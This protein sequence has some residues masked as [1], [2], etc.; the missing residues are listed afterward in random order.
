MKPVIG[1][2][3]GQRLTVKE[4]FL[5]NE[6]CEAIIKNGGLPLILPV[7]QQSELSGELLERCD[8]LMLTGGG[9]IKP[10]FYQ[11]VLIDSLAENIDESRDSFEIAIFKAALE[12]QK[13][14][15][16]ICRGLQ[17]IN[18]ALNG[19]LIQDIDRERPHS[20]VHRA[21]SNLETLEHRVSL[22][23]GTRA[24]RIFGP[25]IQVNSTHHQAVK[26]LGVGLVAVGWSP[27]G[28][29]EA[30]EGVEETWITAVQWHPERLLEQDG[31]NRLFR[32]LMNQ[33]RQ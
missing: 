14:V 29:I 12:G 22:Q 20:L 4:Q 13:P 2:S 6:Y 32:E 24:H 30:I 23:V 9:D 25:N 19:T 7:C 3:C 11:D 10:L 16:G 33:T 28:V 21:E 31:M 18:V 5:R 8:G 27:D 17:V 26:E 1:I 15:L